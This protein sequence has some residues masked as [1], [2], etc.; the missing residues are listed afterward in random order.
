MENSPEQGHR[1]IRKIVPRFLHPYLRG[2]RRR[3][4]ATD[5]PV[6]EPFKTVFPFTQVHI[7]RQRNLGRLATLIRDRK[8]PGVVIECGV[9]DGGSAALMA[10]YSQREIHLFDSWEGLPEASAEDAESG[11]WAGDV[12]GSQKR[13]RAVL[14]K[15]AIDPSRV[16]FHRGWFSDTF[17]RVAEQVDTVALV[18][19]DADFYESVRLSIETWFPKLTSGGFM[20][21]D[22][23]SAFIGCRTAVDQFLATAPNAEM[24]IVDD[25][26]F[27]LEKT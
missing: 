25:I 12:I 9:L 26:V 20:Q 3:L 8:T 14:R 19:I 16:Y 21:F 18:H 15:L 11:I 7:A 6:D 27:Y 23:Y 13:A 24:H 5:R 17:A 1:L 22:D 4:L 10:F 2:L